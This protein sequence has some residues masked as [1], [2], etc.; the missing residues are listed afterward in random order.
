M[1]IWAAIIGVVGTAVVGAG[2]YYINTC[3]LQPI[4]R[5]QQIRNQVAADLDFYANAIT[6]LRD[7]GTLR[8]DVLARQ[9]ANRAR[10]TEL[11]GAFP[12]LPT[13]YKRRLK[14]RGENPLAAAR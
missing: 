12:E 5:Y 6:L 10:A 13:F 11:K 3:C 4:N 14:R 1:E 7:N 2:A 8:Q 9:Q